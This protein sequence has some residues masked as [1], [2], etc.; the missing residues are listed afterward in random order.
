MLPHSEEIL[1]ED[2]SDMFLSHFQTSENHVKSVPIT[3]S[4]RSC[5]KVRR[6]V[7]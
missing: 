4:Q 3:Q 6:I 1:R 5:H 2:E 7:S